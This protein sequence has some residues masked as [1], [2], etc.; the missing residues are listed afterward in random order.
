MLW[1]DIYATGNTAVDA[2]HKEIFSL[3]GK[4]GGAKGNIGESIDFLV[5]YVG[6][7][8][9]HEERLMDESGYAKVAEH[10]AQ[11]KAFAEAAVKFKEKIMKEGESLNLNMEVN[12]TIVDWLTAHIMNS[13][14]A[15]A[16][17]YKSW[18]K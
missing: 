17:H 6:R 18:K 5:S 3:V 10:K 12:K 13:D 2:E 16:T 7:H 14:K 15:L 11:H 8:F 1:S 9:A 4:L